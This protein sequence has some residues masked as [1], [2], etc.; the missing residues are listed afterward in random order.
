M[1]RLKEN[2]GNARGSARAWVDK[3]ARVRAGECLG[4]VKGMMMVVMMGDWLCR[5]GGGPGMGA[6]GRAK[7]RCVG[8]C[9]WGL[10][11]KKS[12]GARAMGEVE[13]MHGCGGASKGRQGE[14][15]VMVRPKE[16]A[17][18]ARGA[19]RACV[20]KRARGRTRVGAWGELE[21]R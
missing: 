19:G 9:V 13:G 1:V 3:R 12:R 14:V 10:H 4:K 6:C 18:N 8:A 7:S 16:N 11:A 15:L 2:A 20:H 5:N 21:K 17:G